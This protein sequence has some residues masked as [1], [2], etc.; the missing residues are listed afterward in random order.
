MHFFLRTRNL[1]ISQK[2]TQTLFFHPPFPF[3]GNFCNCNNIGICTASRFFH[4][5]TQREATPIQKSAWKCTATSRNFLRK[6][7]QSAFTLAN[8]LCRI[9]Q[10]P[11]Y[12]CNRYKSKL[13]PPVI[14]QI[15]W[16]CWV[17]CLHSYLLAS[18][19]QKQMYNC[20]FKASQ[21]GKL[22]PIR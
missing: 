10:Y 14:S 11:V 7:L 13:W 12:I 22:S 9:A 4:C 20:S 15:M 8:Q 2:M 16:G 17:L 1:L 6:R 3:H 5:Y 19:Y 18:F 21:P